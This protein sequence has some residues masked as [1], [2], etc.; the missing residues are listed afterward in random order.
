M[1]PGTSTVTLHITVEGE[2]YEIGTVTVV[3][4]PAH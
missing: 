1:L 2:R 3:V 4:K